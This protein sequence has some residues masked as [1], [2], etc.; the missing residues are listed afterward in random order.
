MLEV[1]RN[2]TSKV[3]HGESNVVDIMMRIGRMAK[4]KEWMAN[5]RIEPL[6]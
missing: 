1:V 3:K 2:A 4:K 6:N 5:A